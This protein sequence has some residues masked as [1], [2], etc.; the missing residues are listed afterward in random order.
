MNLKF[1]QQQQLLTR[2]RRTFDAALRALA[3]TQHELLW[4][5]M[6]DY[7]KVRKYS[8]WQL[9]CVSL[10]WLSLFLSRNGSYSTLCPFVRTWG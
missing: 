9:L 2:V 1:L 10:M 7:V 3:V 8:V 6:M 4:P 5:E